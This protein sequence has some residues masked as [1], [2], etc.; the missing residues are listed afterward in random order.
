MN[1]I[2]RLGEF[3]L[4]QH[5]H[6]E[7]LEMEDVPF[8]YT[9]SDLTTHAMLVGM[10][11]SGKTGLGIDI[12]EEA[13]V[14]GLP[15]MVIDPKGDMANLLLAFPSLTGETLQPWI[16]S[17]AAEQAGMTPEA[18]AEEEARR[19]QEGR[20]K[21]GIDAQRVE[22]LAQADITVYTPGSTTGEPLSLL[23]LA[24]TPPEAIRADIESFN[25]YVSSTVASI[26]ALVDVDADPL[27]SKAHLLLSTL[28]STRWKAGESLDWPSLISAIH[29]PGLDKI[30][31][32]PLEAFYPEKERLALAMR[33]NQLLA[34]PQ[35][36]SWREGAALD[37]Q[38]MLYTTEGKPR[39]AILS[40]AHLQDRERMFVVTLLLNQ[41]VA[42]MRRQGGQSAL[43]ALLYMD[44]MQGY[45]PPVANPPSKSPMMTLL[46]QARAFGLGIVLATQNPA[47]LDYKGLSNMGTWFIGHL[48]T[49]QDRDRLLDGMDT[50]GTIAQN[51]NALNNLL[52]NLPKRTFYVHNIHSREDALFTT[53]WAMSYLAGPLTGAQLKALKKGVGHTT[54][55]ESASGVSV[56]T[57]VT[58]NAESSPV[59]EDAPHT[60][61]SAS[62]EGAGATLPV[63]PKGITAYYHPA[64]GPATYTAYLCGNTSIFFEDQ[65]AGV[66]QE[67]ARLYLTAI[68]EPPM[69]A[70]WENAES[71]DPSAYALQA[72]APQGATFRPLPFEALRGD[73][74]K[75][76]KTSL[77][78]YLYA[79]ARLRISRHR[80]TGLYGQPGEEAAFAIRVD[81]ALRE[82]RDQEMQKIKEKYQRKLDTMQE[83][84]R[85]AELAVSREETQAQAAKQSTLVSVG[86]A[87]L[88]SLLG[89]KKLSASTLGRV[90]SSARSFSRQRAQEED[91]RR[92]EANVEA[93]N[94]E[95]QRLEETMAEEL[96][97]IQEQFTSAQEDVEEVDIKP[98]KMNIQV[99]DL[100]L[101]WVP[102]GQGQE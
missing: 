33:F 60:V 27:T 23:A 38:R 57:G 21:A 64:A 46:K 71:A 29:Q 53:R 7:T 80:S 25:A 102:D 63:L 79:N 40:L 87:L 65:K 19:G 92:A 55:A 69:S 78:N 17:Q 101:V 59:Q 4:G 45:F 22:M 9:S 28:L 85:K 31:V 98:K 81:N 56:E 2:E 72:E 89:R 41:M 68:P 18:Y 97:Q 88:G 5:V 90:G 82:K 70:D 51:R 73:V 34:S 8:L 48:Q 15:A 86:S 42:W 91:I 36:A 26:L 54:T 12:L 11:G 44:E 32:M 3:Y 100:F 24:Q 1:I 77:K 99:Q 58:I 13:I 66:A 94:Q 95:Y 14:D 35:F 83:R 20:Q 39:V 49:Q 6:G 67:R 84:I 47:D 30:G 43:R 61:Q 75:K 37:P 10:T 93:Y 62:T 74:T 96:K 16:S 52:S 50:D 76:E